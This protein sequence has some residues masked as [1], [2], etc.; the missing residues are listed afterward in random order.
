M[1]LVLYI[2]VV[3]DLLQKHK[4]EDSDMRNFKFIFVGLAA[5]LL[6]ACATGPNPLTDQSRD[7]FFVKNTKVTWALPE[8]EEAVEVK[9]DSKDDGQRAEGRKAIE[10]KLILVVANEFANSPSGPTPIDFNI[11]IKRY[12]RVGAAI[13]NMI[14]GSD[15]LVAD[16]IVTDTASGEELAVYEDVKGVRTSNFGILGAV[17]QAASDPDIEGLMADSFTKKLRKKF[18]SDK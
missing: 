9:K 17:V 11:A 10:E 18:D 5:Y 7:Q 8:K 4:R 14:G 2:V 6:A 13:G 15:M 3:S 12:D 16:V 1:R